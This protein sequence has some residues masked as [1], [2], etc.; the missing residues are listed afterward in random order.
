MAS[1]NAVKV[2]VRTKPTS[3]FAQDMINILD[4]NKTINIKLKKKE[5]YIN[6]QQ[7]TWGFAFDEV[8]NNL[9]QDEVYERCGA[10]VTQSA[11]DGFNGTLM[12]YGQTGAGKTF[13]MTGTTENYKHRGI[14]PRAI[15][16]VFREVKNRT[17]SAI[18]V[19]VSYVELYNETMYDLLSFS[20]TTEGNKE[21]KDGN[22]ESEDLKIIEDSTGNTYIMGL[23]HQVANSEEEALHLLFEGET[24]RSIAEH[25]LNKSSTR[26]H[27]IFTL[28]LDIRSRVE[29]SEKI[30]L[31]K[32]NL[33]DLAGS[34][35]LKKTQSEGVIMKEAMY[36]NK[37]LT[38]LEQV[39]IALSDKHRDHIP[40]RR[41]KLT[42]ILKDSL[43]GNC[44]TV[45]VANVWT[46][47][48][49]IEETISTLKFATR[50]MRVSNEPVVNVTYDPAMLVKKY[51]RE[52]KD[53]KAE[54][55]MHDTLSN[56]SHIQYETYTESQRNELNATL[57]KYL[58]EEIDDVDVINLRQIKEMLIQFR[59]IFKDME[60]ETEIKTKQKF[61]REKPPEVDLEQ[62]H[63]GAQGDEDGVGDTEGGGFA[64][65]LAPNKTGTPKGA[66]LKPAPKIPFSRTKSTTKMLATTS[67]PPPPPSSTSSS[68][69]PSPVPPPLS[70]NSS[71]TPPSSTSAPAMQSA[72]ATSSGKDAS[73]GSGSGIMNGPSGDGVLKKAL[74]GS[75]QAA[76]R[77]S[78]KAGEQKSVEAG[79]STKRS[80]HVT[81]EQE[82]Y[83]DNDRPSASPTPDDLRASP[84]DFEKN[85]PP[86]KEEEKKKEEKR[87][88]P[89]DKNS[90]FTEFKAGTGSEV[91]QKLKDNT[92]L[93][94]DKKRILKIAG[95]KVNN[96]KRDIDKLKA[97]AEQKKQERMLRPDFQQMDE[98]NENDT[99]IIDEE[100]FRAITQLRDAKKNYRD[101]YEQLKSIQLEVD[102]ITRMMEQC[103]QK[104]I[105]DFDVWYGNTFV[106][107]SSSSSSVPPSTA[108]KRPALP[109]SNTEDVL[110][111]QEKFDKLG[112]E[113]IVQVEPEAAA[114]YNAAK[115]RQK[116]ELTT[117]KKI[118]PSSPSKSSSQSLNAKKGSPSKFR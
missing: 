39:I 54:L 96:V 85:R 18:T 72:G 56:K 80:K 69:S 8:M 98:D 27:C 25:Q 46:E 74:P 10:A 73:Q 23:T 82:L 60:R 115:L 36:I 45:M 37:S 2:F 75:K 28:H 86:P 110:D 35:R 21:N 61:V 17:D 64:V 70:T 32:L 111:F 90:A 71:P 34:E 63:S 55:A 91:N 95:E 118:S 103:R 43:G 112:F 97:V 13:T 101:A 6:N 11:L 99:E 87:P 78:S 24:N 67:S 7:E 51:E 83:R 62:T 14:I 1:K 84:S 117:S 42:N 33:V 100:E 16:H 89:A 108:D 3:S 114:F 58:A 92:E 30:T 106:A 113:K 79:D 29:S 48:Q 26:S 88:A 105:T 38:F 77:H 31:S 19:R 109:V 5:G 81:I 15:A 49:S 102:T 22:S 47:P 9:S 107:D 104:L 53:L 93:L 94:K 76:R 66:R 4:D 116:K 52:I 41:C 44:K 12:C 57:R 20:G 50:M 65:G 59:V 40:Y 68:P